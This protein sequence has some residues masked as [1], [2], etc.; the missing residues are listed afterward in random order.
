MSTLGVEGLRAERDATLTIA[1]SFT[2]AD[3]N[4]QSDCD[5]WA[6]R[7]VIAH[8]GS[9]LHG[10]VDPSVMPDMS[11]GTE[12]AMEAPVAERREWAVEDV[13]AEFATSSG[14]GAD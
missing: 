11:G 1:K 7:D 6:V 2:D 12:D 3:W 8:M 4:A 13:L 9:I 10:V 5:G 14:T